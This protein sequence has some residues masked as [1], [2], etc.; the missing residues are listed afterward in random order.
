MQ[1]MEDRLV[2]ECH[3]LIAVSDTLRDKL[4]HAGRRAELLTHGVDLEH[5][6]P[7]AVTEPCPNCTDC[8][9]RWLFSGASW[10]GAWTWSG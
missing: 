4:A 10:I 8:R 3:R 1:L 6:K 7:T 9:D 2:R 5:W